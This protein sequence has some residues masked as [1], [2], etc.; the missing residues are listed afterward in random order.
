MSFWRLRQ[1]AIRIRVPKARMS[2][3][4][5]HKG[6]LSLTNLIADL[7]PRSALEVSKKLIC[8]PKSTREKARRGL[9]RVRYLPSLSEVGMNFGGVTTRIA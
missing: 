6:G 3:L 5:S 9:R 4:D 1:P 7:F 8:A 2:A